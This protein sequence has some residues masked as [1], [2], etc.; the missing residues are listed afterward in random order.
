MTKYKRGTKGTFFLMASGLGN[1]IMAVANTIQLLFYSILAQVSMKNISPG[2]LP[3]LDY[4]AYGFEGLGYKDILL[5]HIIFLLILIFLS[6]LFA[7]QAFR[8]SY[9]DEMST[10]FIVAGTV[11]TI[12]TLLY[13][14]L[15]FNALLLLQL[16]IWILLMI[17]GFL[18]RQPIPAPMPSDKFRAFDPGIPRTNYF[19]GPQETTYPRRHQQGPYSNTEPRFTTRPPADGRAQMNQP[20]ANLRYPD[21]YGP[22]ERI[23][24]EVPPPPYNNVFPPLHNAAGSGQPQPPILPPNPSQ[25]PVP[26]PSQNMPQNPPQGAVPPAAPPPYPF[27]GPQPPA[28][29][30]PLP[31]SGAQN[32]QAPR[33]LPGPWPGQAAAGSFGPPAA[34]GQSP[35]LSPPPYQTAPPPAS[36]FGQAGPLPAAGAGKEPLPPAAAAAADANKTETPQAAEACNETKAAETAASGPAAAAPAREAMKPAAAAGNTPLSPAAAL[37]ETDHPAQAETAAAL[38][39]SAAAAPEPSVDAAPDNA[40]QDS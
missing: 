18:C 20:P 29:A 5:I 12:L 22:K 17:G 34:S 39:P 28:A 3:G 36:R 13:F 14:I 38:E 23:Y 1:V 9:D 31:P 11:L 2:R 24:R 10:G 30:R 27:P 37:S 25:N 19:K 6:A 8:H 40:G 32:S 16:L 4:A 15:S 33:P 35:V 26:N 7:I 21:P